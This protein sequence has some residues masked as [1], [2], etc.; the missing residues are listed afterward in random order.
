MPAI[1]PS[2][3]MDLESKMQ[4]VTDQEY[5]R[6]NSHLWW[7]RFA[8]V[9]NTEAGRELLM[10]LL[11]T[12]QIQQ[13]EAAE[14]IE[15]NDLVAQIMEVKPKYAS[16][17]MRLARNQLE[18]V[19]GN[20]LQL[21]AEWSAQ[22]GAYMQYWPQKLVSTFLQN[23]HTTGYAT[24]YDNLP[25]FS[26]SH[27]VHPKD[28]SK[29]TYANLF[30]GAASGSYPGALDISVAVT[31]DVALAN[32]A[33]LNGYV[34]GIKMPN[35]EDPRGLRVAG[36]GC[37]P[38]MFPRVAQLTNAKFI[39]QAVGSAGGSADVEALVAALGYGQPFQM[40]ELAGFES[41]TTY[42]VVLEQTNINAVGGLIY[43]DRL[44]FKIDYYG[45]QTESA[46]GRMQ[47]F[48]WQLHGR[49]AVLPGHPYLVLKVKAA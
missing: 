25:F 29:G 31:A 17:G 42:F 43:L 18:D 35:G 7:Q 38:T 23:A 46:L 4:L 24:A 39:A 1:L 13:Q 36:I 14:I 26:A 49:N 30:T 19:D 40:D 2:F 47:T 37:S 6:L 9:K 41:D 12:A 32:L 5:S 10:W 15:F 22:I 3:I 11:S 33:K 27:L 28:S 20:G 21:A 44:G 34:A 45:P 8:K 16:T 48:E